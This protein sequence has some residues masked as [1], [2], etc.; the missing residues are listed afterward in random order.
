MSTIHRREGRAIAFYEPRSALFLAAII[1]LTQPVLALELNPIPLTP[2]QWQANGDVSFQR[3]P[4]RQDVLVVNKGYAELK[5]TD[6]SNGTIEF[7]TKFV[8]ERIA[9]IT[10]RQHD[11]Q[12]DALYF[13][14]SADC[15]ASDECIQYMPTAHH[16]FE[17]DLYGQ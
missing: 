6:F 3:D 16:V 12:A 8:G 4:A 14:P 11:D 7:D 15:A 13:R 9:G 2:Q 10:F 5:N 17:W 1:G